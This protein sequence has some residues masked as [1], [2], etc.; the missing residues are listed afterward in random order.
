MH[1]SSEQGLI[2]TMKLDA[3]LNHIHKE[4]LGNR[5]P[6]GGGGEPENKRKGALSPQNCVCHHHRPKYN[7]Q[8]NG[9]NK[10]CAKGERR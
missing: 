6:G 3:Y 2:L 1:S 5:G 4:G 8:W 9:M 7:K 10:G